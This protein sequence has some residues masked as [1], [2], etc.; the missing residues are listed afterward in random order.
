MLADQKPVR[1][2]AEKAFLAARLIS[3]EEPT[4][5]V[6]FAMSSS[7]GR[8][9]VRNQYVAQMCA[10]SGLAAL[11]V[12]LLTYE[13]RKAASHLN[14]ALLQDRLT[15]TLVWLQGQPSLK[16]LPVGLFATNT[17]A[18]AALAIAGSAWANIRAVVGRSARLSYASTALPNITCPVLLISASSE[19]PTVVEANRKAYEQLKC[20]KEL[21]VVP[22]C[23]RLFSEPAALQEM[24]AL[25]VD[26]LTRYLKP[27]HM[28]AEK[29]AV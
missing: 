22:G 6:V 28:E 25:A 26:W 1:I 27:R 15:A 17:A 5:V 18:G 3:L 8:L 13:D 14:L 9:S 19:H 11:L 2:Q 7:S 4:G 20:T 24:T 29:V 16:D 23:S 10:R 21:S 12:D